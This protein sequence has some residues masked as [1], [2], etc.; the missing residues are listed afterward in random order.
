MIRG[1]QLQFW[2][3]TSRF[4]LPWVWHFLQEHPVNNHRLWVFTIP[5]DLRCSSEI[6]SKRSLYWEFL[7]SS[8]HLRTGY[9]WVEDA[10]VQRGV[11]LRWV[12]VPEVCLVQSLQLLLQELFPQ[13]WGSLALQSSAASLTSG[14]GPALLSSSNTFPSS[15]IPVS[16]SRQTGIVTPS[17]QLCPLWL[18]TAG[19]IWPYKSTEIFYHIK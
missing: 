6:F 14:P 1:W 15:A 9:L 3:P 11:S 17:G 19:K 16:P 2:T 5:P 12:S 7:G 4:Y 13:P 18:T 10:L 8:Q